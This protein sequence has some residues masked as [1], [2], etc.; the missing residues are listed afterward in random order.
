MSK[1]LWWFRRRWKKGLAPPFAP[2]LTTLVP[3]TA[4]HGSGNLA[5]TINGSHFTAGSTINFGAAVY[6]ATFVSPTQLSATILAANLAT[7]GS[8]NVTVQNPYGQT[9]GILVFTI[10]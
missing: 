10:T 7:A 3:N 8:V 2:T 1:V 6:S 4:V 5:L 9:S